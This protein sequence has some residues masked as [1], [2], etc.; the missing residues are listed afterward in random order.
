MAN[1][2][3]PTIYIAA[4]SGKY[5][6]SI[7]DFTMGTYYDRIL[8]GSILDKHVFSDSFKDLVEGIV[9]STNPEDIIS[10]LDKISNKINIKGKEGDEQ[11]L[12]LFGKNQ[13]DVIYWADS[14]Q[15][16][17]ETRGDELSYQTIAEN[18]QTFYDNA[19]PYKMDT[20]FEGLKNLSNQFGLNKKILSKIYPRDSYF[21]GEGRKATRMFEKAGY[22][23]VYSP[24]YGQDEMEDFLVHI[25]K[26]PDGKVVF[27][28][29]SG[30][31]ENIMF[32]INHREWSEL[33]ARVRD[34][35][36][37]F[38]N[39]IFMAACDTGECDIIRG[40][41]GDKILENADP[42]Q[43]RGYIFDVM[44]NAAESGIEQF[45]TESERG[46]SGPS[47]ISA[48]HRATYEGFDES[49][50]MKKILNDFLLQ[51][52]RFEISETFPE[53]AFVNDRS[54]GPINFAQAI[55]GNFPEVTINA[56]YGL[57]QTTLPSRGGYGSP[58]EEIAAMLY[59]N[60]QL[61]SGE[62]PVSISTDRLS[63][64][65]AT[66]QRGESVN[67]ENE[68]LDIMGI[69]KLTGENLMEYYEGYESEDKA[70][71]AT[72]LASPFLEK[73]TDSSATPFLNKIFELIDRQFNK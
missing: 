61:G 58:E 50:N 15:N 27:M 20:N 7:P 65:I 63:E 16:M 12:N 6:E 67:I 41:Y 53:G 24:V 44:N 30:G 73:E 19:L 18:F 31:M 1:N 33:S 72:K 47:G 68:L 48:F 35:G 17:R 56:P 66:Y 29:H 23:V 8:K 26:D 10:H 37:N 57:W 45:L 11:F 43:I 38:T 71:D 32:G 4:E 2:N 22:N 52:R 60:E 21:E 42:D 14:Y 28:G 13:Q 70:L 9:G 64:H 46:Y 36:A 69:N 5:G 49:F 34:R 3:K 25:S 39:E 59:S 54:S 55:Q 51:D 62:K 40:E